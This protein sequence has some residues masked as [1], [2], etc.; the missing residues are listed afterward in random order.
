MKKSKNHLLIIIAMSLITLSA[1]KKSSSNQSPQFN[2]FGSAL[3]VSSDAASTASFT[4][5]I[6]NGVNLQPSYYNNGNVNLG[7]SLMKNYSSKIKTV[8]IEIDMVN[9]KQLEFNTVKSWLSQALY[10]GYSVI[11]TYHDYKANGSNDTQYVK[12]ATNWWL[13]HYEDLSKIGPFHVNL[14]N[15]WGDHNC[16]LENYLKAYNPALARLRQKFPKIGTIIIDCP[17][18]GQ[19]THTMSLAIKALNDKE[20]LPSVHIYPLANASG[21]TLNTADLEELQDAT[22]NRGA[23]IGE[24]GNYPTQPQLPGGNADWKGLVKYASSLNWKVLGWSWNGDGG[25]MNMTAPSWLNSK[26]PEGP[27]SENKPYST[28][29]FDLL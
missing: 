25:P 10:S 19:E 3:G 12:N 29:I 26:D 14:I 13:T 9:N 15:E 24:F 4:G 23:I 27:L 8:R 22:N 18:W 21:H 11:L 16:T 28:E 17:G 5:L 20:V 6:G 2:S 7:F 1:C